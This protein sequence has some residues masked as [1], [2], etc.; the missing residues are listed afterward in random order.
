MDKLT[1]KA[2]I[3]LSASTTSSLCQKTALDLI[4]RL[5]DYEQVLVHIASL[6]EPLPKQIA[7]KALDDFRG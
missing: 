7:Q 1:S 5:H 4:E 6:P 3:E 2:F